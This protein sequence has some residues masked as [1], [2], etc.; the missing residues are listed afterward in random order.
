MLEPSHLAPGQMIAGDYR[1]VRLLAQGG[2][3]SVYVVEQIS[4]SRQRAL[5]VLHA[6]FSRQDGMRRRFEQE[7][8][9]GAKIASEHVVE[10]LAAGVDDESGTPWLVMELLEGEDLASRLARVGRFSPSEV[11]AIMAQVGHALAAAHAQGIVHRD[12]KPENIFLATSRRLGTD[13][14][15]KILDFGIAKVVS[16]AQTTSTDRV[17]TPLYMAPEQTTT[18]EA[19]GPAAD[20]W[21]LGLIVFQ[22]LTGRSYWK[23]AGQEGSSPIALLREVVFEP[24]PSA[25]ARA[26]ELGVEAHLPLGFDA[27]FARA[28]AR[29]P[30]ARF[31]NA[32]L[33]QAELAAL[34]PDGP[35]VDVLGATL[36]LSEAM[37][38][39]SS[40]RI[41]GT[42]APLTTTDRQPA[43]MGR[44][45]PWPALVAVAGVVGA[46]AWWFTRSPPA[47]PDSHAASATAVASDTPAA[48]LDGAL[49]ASAARGAMVHICD[50]PAGDPRVEHCQ[51]P[52]FAWCD[53]DERFVAC[54]SKSLI[55][56]GQSGACGCAPGGALGEQA[57]AAGCPKAT[58]AQGLDAEIVK[59]VIRGATEKMR[60]CY[61][62]ALDSNPAL[63]GRMVLD[64]ELTPWGDVFSATIRESS[65]PDPDAQECMLS[66][67]RELRFP[68]LTGGGVLKVTYPFS[69]VN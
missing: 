43:P 46:G 47:S 64:L 28:V 7:A 31:A 5:K 3:G 9:V 33:A 53:R 39:A 26:L 25:S 11:L 44:R 45:A 51:E 6:Q 10:V 58:G 56:V 21:A 69:L 65:V 13:V 41:D 54:C 18:G 55:P 32:A 27:W 38:A 1:V 62:R 17:G 60:A 52:S 16:E 12:L 68:A 24:M 35:P 34:F 61:Q 40:V 42:G 19:I 63:R 30:A 15:V 14:V 67:A 37:V 50:K 59:D 57:I 23:G 29:D 49:D 66:V 20:V 36:P 8:R 4:T 22:L 2:M 48:P